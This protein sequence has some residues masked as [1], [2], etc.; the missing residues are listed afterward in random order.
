M[1]P[2]TFA[3][4]I[5]ITVV[6]ALALPN[7]LAAQE[8]GEQPRYSVV[9]LGTLGG[10]SSVAYSVNKRGW[11]AGTASLPGN[12][13]QHAVLWRKGTKTDLGTLGGPNSTAFFPLNDRGEVS[14]FSDTPNADPNGED[15][16]GFGTHLVCNPF[17]WQDG[18]KTVLP[19]LG[20]NNA[21]ANEVNNRG[22]VGGVA[23]T[24]TVDPTCVAPQVLQALPVV[25]ENGEIEELPTFPGDPDGFVNAINDS[26]QA[27]GASGQCYTTAP[28]VHALL[29]R[30][31]S[32]TDL[33]NLGGTMNHF[34]QDINNQGQVVG[35]SALPGN[36]TIH[37]FLWEDGVITDLGTLP[38]DFWSYAFSIN[39]KAQIVGQSCN[40]DFSVCRAF[41]WQKGLM[42]DLNSLISA[43]SALSLLVAYNVNDRG[44]ITGQGFDQNNGAAQAFLAI[45][46]NEDSCEAASSSVAQVPSD[47]RKIALAE[48]RSQTASPTTALR[49]IRSYAN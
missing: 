26:G 39:S 19:T 46:C 10:T 44:E 34:P 2:Q 28:G 33:G 43:G 6:A 17:V 3:L 7:R 30:N 29:W 32:V 48:K 42:T 11:V 25:W 41:L 22:Q 31:G 14:G 38:G 1:K 4:I 18:G 23:E 15:F 9:D 45:P 16:C 47:P 27:V 5:A 35:F 8:Q 24:R 40:S 13:A 21:I 12:T 36:T 37:G 20:G 49:P